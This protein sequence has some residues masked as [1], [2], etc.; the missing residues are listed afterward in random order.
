MEAY[1]LD[2]WKTYEN[3]KQQDDLT[4]Y[5]FKSF[6]RNTFAEAAS[7]NTTVNEYRSELIHK[8]VTFLVIAIVPLLIA[9]F[10]FLSADYRTSRNASQESVQQTEQ[11]IRDEREEGATSTTAAA[12][13]I[14]Q[15]GR[16][17][18]ETPVS[19]AAE[20]EVAKPGDGE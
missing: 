13:K 8:C 18:A 10:V 7:F 9:F 6:L 17:S 3:Y 20:A 11:R 1:R 2:I 12:A 5:Y 4:E 16:G 19:S 14:H 15:E